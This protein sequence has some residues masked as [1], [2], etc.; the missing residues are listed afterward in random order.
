MEQ[1]RVIKPTRRSMSGYYCH[2]GVSIPYES[3]LERDFVVF[4]TFRSNVIEVVAQPI[5][6]PFEKNGRTYNYT[7]DYFVQIDNDGD[8]Y[9]PDTKSLIVEVKPRDEWTRH[10]RDWSDKWKAAKEYCKE[11]DYRFKIYDESRIRHQGLANVDHIMRYE[12]LNCSKDDI[13]TILEQVE[14]MGTTTIE[15]LL[16][17]FFMGDIYRPQGRRI[18]YHLMATKRLGFH[19]WDEINEKTEVWY[20]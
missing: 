11:H 14:M 1:V 6:I 16:E 5:A 2:Q 9:N 15:Y 18:I 13:E 8:R 3:T 7:P 19:L 17:R 12:R 4:Q 20:V 10:W